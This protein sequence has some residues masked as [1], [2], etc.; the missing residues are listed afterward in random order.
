MPQFLADEKYVSVPLEETYQAA[1]KA[2]PQ[3]LR[4]LVEGS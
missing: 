3:V 4:A 2:S 1:W